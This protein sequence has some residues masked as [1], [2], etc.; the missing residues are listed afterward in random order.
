MKYQVNFDYS[1]PTHNYRSW[2]VSSTGSE[3]TTKGTVQT[4]SELVEPIP[5]A[6]N[7]STSLR[8][9]FSKGMLFWISPIKTKLVVC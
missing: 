1:G 5:F 8:T 3:L 2:F 7:P 4:C 6:L 9:G